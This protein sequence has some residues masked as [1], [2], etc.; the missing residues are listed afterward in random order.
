M[1]DPCPKDVLVLIPGAVNKPCH[2]ALE[3]GVGSGSVAAIP[4]ADLEV[5]KIVL[6]HSGGHDV[7]IKPLGK[8]SGESVSEKRV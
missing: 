1:A 7:V 3:L 5:G 8:E 4:S 2:L 6:D